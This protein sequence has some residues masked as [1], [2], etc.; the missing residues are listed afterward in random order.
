LV[1][2]CTGAKDLGAEQQQAVASER[3]SSKQTNSEPTEKKPAEGK[4]HTP[5]GAV[6]VRAGEEAVA[7]AGT[8]GKHTIARVGGTNVKGED[9]TSATAHPAEVVLKIE[10]SPGTEFSGTCTVGGKENKI[11]GR[12]PES[13][14]YKAEGQWLECEI[15]KQSSNSGALK[16][17]FT[18]GDHTNSVQQTSA[19]GGTI[20]LRYE[21]GGST[22]L[23]SSSTSVSGDQ[24]NSSSQVIV[25]QS[26]SS[27]EGNSSSQTHA[28]ASQ[29][30][31]A[32]IGN[33]L[34]RMH[35]PKLFDKWLDGSGAHSSKRSGSH[36]EHQHQHHH[37]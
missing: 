22:D 12:V 6:V 29:N 15:R 17:M 2:G 26:S 31:C 16:V 28:S 11:S 23:C 32:H 3:T 4:L 7:Q 27:S 14:V 35:L 33:E 10:G 20:T 37:N 8:Y 19:Q 24:A 25:S 13:F 9:G 1:V 30:S 18:A 36:H 5:K 21:S 34:L